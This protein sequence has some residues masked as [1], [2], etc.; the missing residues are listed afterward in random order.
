MDLVVGVDAG[1]TSTRAVV[2]TVDGRIVGRGSGGAGNP[3][4]AG[5]AA[6][7]SSLADALRAAL[8]GVPAE[9]VVRGV[10]GVAGTSALTAGGGSAYG[11]VW[12][13]LGLTC[14]RVVV[15]DAVTAFAAGSP[16]PGGIVLIAGTGAI[17]AEVSGTSVVRTVDGNGW[18]LGDLGS[19]RWIGLAA[20]RC[21]VRQWSSPFAASIASRA[22]VTSADALIRWAQRLPFA[23]IDALAPLVCSLARAG[24]PL[25]GSITSAAARELIRSLD[26]LPRDGPVVLAGGLLA[27]DTPVHDGVR[28]VLDSRGV[29]CTRSRDPAAAA[30]WLAARDLGPLAAEELHAV[31]LR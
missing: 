17:A 3:L 25:A 15:G 6:A 9:R 10:L 1:G 11:K 19:G 30:A 14:P 22:G 29:P 5:P 13:R 7:A 23:E 31:L 28:S 12:T 2:A 21:A 18:L 26:E 24:D 16:A 4:T 27:A 8:H 20:L